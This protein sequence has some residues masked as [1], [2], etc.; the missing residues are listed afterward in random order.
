[1]ETTALPRAPGQHSKCRPIFWE[2]SGPPPRAWAAHTA[3]SVR[4]CAGLPPVVVEAQC[5]MLRVRGYHAPCLITSRLPPRRAARSAPAPE[6]TRRPTPTL[7][8]SGRT[9]S[10]WPGPGNGLFACQ[11]A[12]FVRQPPPWGRWVCQPSL[13][14]ARPEGRQVRRA[15]TSSTSLPGRGAPTWR[16]ARRRPVAALFSLRRQRLPQPGHR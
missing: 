9:R 1:M 3:G 5:S 16:S 14:G 15:V 6:G 4:P 11:G 10:R 8:R 13:F 2:R 12:F 7:T